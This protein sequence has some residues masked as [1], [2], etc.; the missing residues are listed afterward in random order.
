MVVDDRVAARLRAAD[1]PTL[2][3]FVA[4]CAERWAQAFCLIRAQDPGRSDDV[5]LVVEALEALWRPGTAAQDF[6]DRRRR[7]MAF[8]E[9]QPSEVGLS[10]PEELYPFYAALVL[11]YA[12]TCAASGDGE[13]A[14]SCAHASLTASDQLDRNVTGAGFRQS[15]AERQAATLAQVE[16]GGPV[17]QLRDAD[18]STAR[19][20]ART[21]GDRI[22]R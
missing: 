17:E 16:A 10:R 13:A 11:R 12:L 20:L 6:G 7:I 1:G 19:A 22:R 9:L 18:R 5:A 21:I 8:P 15:E 3:V 2:R 4:G 14:V